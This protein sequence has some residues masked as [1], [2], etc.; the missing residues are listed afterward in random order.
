[1]DS[2]GGREGIPEGTAGGRW[3][4]S[5]S[6]FHRLRA[7]AAQGLRLPAQ[8]LHMPSISLSLSFLPLSLPL[9]LLREKGFVAKHCTARPGWQWG[10][11]AAAPFRSPV[12]CSHSQWVPGGL[13][14]QSFGGWSQG[15]VRWLFQPGD[16][17]QWPRKC[18]SFQPH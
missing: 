16:T 7:S 1:M 17:D 6:A 2:G 12:S 11:G 9:S 13:T 4:G 15:R 10:L 3:E 18:D 8:W 14:S 5:F